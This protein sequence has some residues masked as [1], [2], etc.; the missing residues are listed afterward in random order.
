VK[1]DRL[2][3][4]LAVLPLDAPIRQLLLENGRFRELYRDEHYSVL[5]RATVRGLARRAPTG[6]DLEA[7]AGL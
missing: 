6:P 7:R 4:D 2:A 3:V 5:Q 1:F